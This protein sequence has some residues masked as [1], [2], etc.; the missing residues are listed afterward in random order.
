[1]P[2][3]TTISGP[4]LEAHIR[5]LSG[6]TLDEL[7]DRAVARTPDAVAMVIR[8][9]LRDKRWTYRHLAEVVDR[10]AATLAAAGARPGDRVLTWSQNDPWLVA[11][12]FA[13]WRLD[14]VVVP[15]DLRM[16]SDVAIRIGRRAGAS[17]L[18]AGPDV[19]RDVA[20]QLGVPILGMGEADL[21]PSGRR[22]RPR[23][24][25][26]GVAPDDLAELVFTSGTTS[27]PKGVILTHAQIVHTA[28]AIAQTAMGPHPDRG[29]A[30]I[31]LS[32]MYGQTVPLLMGLMSG[33][34]LVFLHS[35]T[36]RALSATLR[37]ERITAITLTPHIM[38]IVL[39]GIEAEVRRQGRERALQ[40]GR[41]VARWLPR[42]LRR[43]LFRQVLA[44]L[45]GLDVISSGGAMLPVDLQRAFETFGIRVIQ[46]YGTTEV[47]AIT[48][49]SRARQRTGTVGPPL[50]GMAVRIAADGELL[51]R[52]PNVM[53]GYW[54]AAEATTEVLD[55]DGW[56]H[57]GDAARIDDR[58]ELVILG[59][60]R[61]RIALPS[62]LNVYPEDVEGAL[63]GTGMV[64][65]AVVIE[66]SPGQLAAAL[67]P[68]D[69]R[70]ADDQL[71]D[72]V[73]AAN[74]T[75]APH[76]RVRSWRRWPDAD[77]PRTHTLKVRRAPVLEWFSG[78]APDEATPGV[79]TGTSRALV[80]E[81]S[82]EAV[83]SVVATVLAEARGTPPAQVTGATTL[84]SL[85]L[86]SLTVV[87]V[88]LRLESAFDAPLSDDDVLRA[89]D[90]SDLHAT[91]VGR[92]GS[93]AEPLPS[94]WA[95]SRPARIMRR[96]LD[97]TVVGWAID[98]VAGPEVEGEDH[99]ADLSGPAL[100]CPNHTSH[101]DAPLV[102]AALPSA[103]RDRTAIAAAADYWFS[104]RRT[105]PVV[106]LVLGAIPFGRTSDVR[107]SLD[108]IAELVDRGHTVIVFPEGTRSPDGR[109]GPLRQ[110]IGLLATRL[111]VPIVP[112]SI[113]GAHEILPKGERCPS[114]RLRR[115]AVV[116]FGAPLRF[117]PETPVA[118]ATQRVQRAMAACAPDG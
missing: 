47:A 50:A 88:A 29:L 8:H 93:D 84:R 34:T 7:L 38:S 85:D 39:Q 31:P 67:V 100:V 36:P 56:F 77:F 75:L 22:D 94:D 111:G 82:V 15:L 42:S 71:A 73:K 113:D 95:F 41:A 117:E 19:D 66:P 1:L 32:H 74:A 114:H 54:E 25:F 30:I 4:P 87:S 40:R 43:L 57:T 3:P 110:G 105:G 89:T 63:V 9:D 108:H 11:A 115:R 83:A 79:P 35:L 52:G 28:R 70:A 12:Y 102:R 116:R 112:V 61:D 98:I 6:E 14:A 103:I 78:T 118:E 81:I 51:A 72:A 96:L 62:G 21:D 90:V 106:E 17:L 69:P 99:L 101:L 109:L 23:P 59:R 91:I 55:A 33:S 10:V 46:G 48:G 107:A 53:R 5:E 16:Q 20:A 80:T 64:R 27:D 18:L 49:H 26:P 45:G 68:D 60:T 76:Q 58:G 97:A 92:Q 13:I 86:D 44:S 65:A 24:T 104:G 2:G 37:R